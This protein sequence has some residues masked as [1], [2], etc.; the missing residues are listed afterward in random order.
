MSRALAILLLCLSTL[1]AQQQKKK[2]APAAAP[3]AAAAPT[4]QQFAIE[5]IAVEGIKTFT[6]AQVIAASGVKVGDIG[7]KGKFDAARDPCA[8][9]R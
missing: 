5:T 1:C 6:A 8:R 9:F 4:V 7:D 3:V 2:A